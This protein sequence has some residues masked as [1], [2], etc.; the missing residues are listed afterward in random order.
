VRLSEPGGGL[1]AVKAGKLLS[2]TSSGVDELLLA[3]GVGV[4]LGVEVDEELLGVD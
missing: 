4:G 3:A 1:A 2:F